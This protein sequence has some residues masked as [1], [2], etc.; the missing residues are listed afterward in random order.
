MFEKYSPASSVPVSIW[1]GTGRDTV[2]IACIT[3]FELLTGDTES[4]AVEC[5]GLYGFSQ[6]QWIFVCRVL[7]SRMFLSGRSLRPCSS[8]QGSQLDVEMLT[9]VQTICDQNYYI[10]SRSR[11]RNLNFDQC[12]LHTR[13]VFRKLFSKCCRTYALLS[14]LM[15]KGTH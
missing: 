10:S 11:A 3:G 2:G 8:A 15:Q 14:C 6:T 1:S 12:Y 13:K 4:T 9:F 5:T 7:R